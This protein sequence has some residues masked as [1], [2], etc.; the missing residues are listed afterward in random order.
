MIWF[1]YCAYFVL[2]SYIGGIHPTLPSYAVWFGKLYLGEIDMEG[3][4]F[5]A[6]K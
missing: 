2:R 1:S 3:E 4:S 5:D 6:A